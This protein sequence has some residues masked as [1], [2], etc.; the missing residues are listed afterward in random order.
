MHHL[1]EDIVSDV[2]GSEQQIAIVERTCDVQIDE[3]VQ[4]ADI[5]GRSGEEFC[6]ED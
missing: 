5:L 6:N 1:E 4:D 2:E 3:A